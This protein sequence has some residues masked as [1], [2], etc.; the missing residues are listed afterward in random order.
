MEHVDIA[1]VV[2]AAAPY[3]IDKPYD[4]LIP[5]PLLSMVSPGVRVTIPFGRGNSSSE[6]FVLACTTGEKTPRLKA[7]LTVLDDEPVLD[8]DGIALA[9]FLRQ[10]CFCTMY[11]ALKTILPAG[12]WYQMRERYI[13]AE[14]IEDSQFAEFKGGTQV[15]TVIRSC[16]GSA[17]R[18]QLR[19]A[20]GVRVS[21]TLKELCD[22]G[23]LKR[24]TETLRRV[25]DKTKRMAELAVD[26]HTALEEAAR[27]EK[28]SPTRSAVLRMLASVG[29]ISAADLRYYTG[30]T[31]T[32]L[33]NM[34]TS[35]LIQLRE[36]EE[37]RVPEI[38]DVLPGAPILL[39]EEQEHAYRSVCDLTAAGKPAAVL[40]HGV[41][42]SGKTQVYIRLVQDALERGRT[43]MVLVPEII[44]TPQ[45]MR[46][47]RSYFGERVVMLHS[48]LKLS[49]RYDQWKRIRRGEVD[50]VLG[51][52]SAVFS[53][54]KNLGLIILDEEQENSY[55]SENTPRYH[56]RDVAKFLCARHNAVLLLGS[57]TPDI[58]SAWLA[59]EGVYQ[60]LVLRKRY[61]IGR[62]HV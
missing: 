44:L 11:D 43:A 50:V 2:V 36:E 60:S 16:N 57:A 32:A 7:I 52:R 13:P 28:R 61:K 46:K 4:Y 30:V 53:P 5:D 25:R 47:F 8:A 9:F 55:Q 51:T 23:L 15:L 31:A 38:G 6:G 21:D 40:L 54:M 29:S 27:R 41:T 35:G 45:M 14:G 58:Q 37:L 20:C 33:K 24:E 39:N 19:A 12:L 59:R 42:G 18:E 62:A 26:P 49:E 22:A 34:E 48:D 17:D 1:R 3:S 56:A 10:R